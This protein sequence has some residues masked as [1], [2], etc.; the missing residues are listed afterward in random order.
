MDPNPF[1]T[2]LKIV[3]RTQQ[4][5]QEELAIQELEVRNAAYNETLAK[6]A[7]EE[8]ELEVHCATAKEN[9]AKAVK[10]SVNKKLF[11]KIAKIRRVA[12][13]S[14]FFFLCQKGSTNTKR[15]SQLLWT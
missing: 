14:F 10:W 6:L 3:A 12:K 4:N 8:K 5:R 9:M 15:K 13:F 7:D 11:T 2:I 1:E